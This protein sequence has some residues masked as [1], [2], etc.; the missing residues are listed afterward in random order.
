MGRYDH[1]LTRMSCS[2]AFVTALFCLA[3]RSVL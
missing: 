1:L 2:P 3:M